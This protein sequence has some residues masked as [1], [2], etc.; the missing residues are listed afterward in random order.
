[1][2][3]WI[4]YYAKAMS[5]NGV[6]IK[7]CAIDVTLH[8]WWKRFHPLGFEVCTLT[9]LPCSLHIVPLMEWISGSLNNY[10]R[11][12]VRSFPKFR[13]TT[14]PNAPKNHV[15][16]SRHKKERTL[17]GICCFSIGFY[18][19]WAVDGWDYATRDIQF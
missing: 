13:V 6:I 8:R 2:T 11:R 7:K 1:M 5:S 16:A 15:W 17:C 12:C 14:I 10:W 19:R 18:F 4:T 9:R 3:S